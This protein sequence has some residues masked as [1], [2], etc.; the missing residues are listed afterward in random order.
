MTGIWMPCANNS[1]DTGLRKA[2]GIGFQEFWILDPS[3][4]WYC[5]S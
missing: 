3:N 5:N 4:G 1:H 2:A